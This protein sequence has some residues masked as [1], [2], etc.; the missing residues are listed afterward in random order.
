MN[1]DLGSANNGKTLKSDPLEIEPIAAKQTLFQSDNLAVRVAPSKLAV[2]PLIF[3]AETPISPGRQS[4]LIDRSTQGRAKSP[5]KSP[6]KNLLRK[7][8]QESVKQVK[9]SMP[10]KVDYPEDDFWRKKKE[11]DELKKKKSDKFYKWAKGHAEKYDNATDKAQR[12]K[13]EAFANI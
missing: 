9:L 6:S 4:P 11:A 3:E 5:L 12:A 2:P 8:V 10:V 1:K 7:P 13:Q